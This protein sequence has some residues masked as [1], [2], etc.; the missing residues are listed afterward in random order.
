M[1]DKG[2]YDSSIVEKHGRITSTYK[3]FY[4]AQGRETEAREYTLGGMRNQLRLDFTWKLDYKDSNIVAETLR[5]AVM[6][7]TIVMV[8]PK[9]L[10]LD[11]VIQRMDRPE[12]TNYYDYLADKLNTTHGFT[13][14]RNL[15]RRKVTVSGPNDTSQV[16]NMRYTFDE[17]GRVLTEV[18]E[19]VPG[20]RD[21]A[22][23]QL[24]YDSS[25][26]TYY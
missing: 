24:E 9:M 17:K 20:Y 14:S 18:M 15:A 10:K 13:N 2:Q 4:D 19:S 3:H 16:N 11:T 7:D 23:M 5:F 21:G 26:Y 1:N 22:S 8:N 25:A 12:V 6:V